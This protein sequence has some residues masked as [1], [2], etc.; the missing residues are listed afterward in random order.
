MPLFGFAVKKWSIIDGIV[1]IICEHFPITTVP[2][3]LTQ[4]KKLLLRKENGFV[5]CAQ[6]AP[7]GRQLLLATGLQVGSVE[8][9]G[10]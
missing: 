7:G 4:G 3:S 5:T 8:K 1:R 9:F 2:I 6:W 10:S